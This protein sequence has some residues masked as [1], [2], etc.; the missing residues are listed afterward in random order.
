M[1]SVAIADDHQLI[2]EG[3]KEII[4]KHYPD[5]ALF[6][7]ANLFELQQLLDTKGIDLLFQDI[8]FGKDDARLFL[9]KL[10]EHNP[11]LKIVIISSVE[12]IHTIQIMK[13]QGIDGYLLKSDGSLELIH[14][15]EA[16][17]RGEFYFSVGVKD[18]L[19]NH[20]FVRINKNNIQLTPREKEVLSLILNEKT[21]KEIAEILFLSEKTIET[22]RANLLI[23]FDVRYLAGLVKKAVL[24]GFV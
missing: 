20:S 24:E 3:F 18:I 21:T 19:A 14:C 6:S 4:K 8:R 12:D 11:H 5:V 7:A 15:M 13:N 2:I 22:H 1:T 16:M 17:G 10:K 9:H 23:K